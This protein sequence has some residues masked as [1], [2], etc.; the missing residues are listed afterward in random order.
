[1]LHTY[2][3]KHIY[4]LIRMLMILMATKCLNWFVRNVHVLPFTIQNC[5]ISFQLFANCLL[6]VSRNTKMKYSLCLWLKTL[7][8]SGPSTY[9]HLPQKKL[10]IFLPIKNPPLNLIRQKNHVGGSDKQ[11]T[12]SIWYIL[13]LMLL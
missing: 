6:N 4:I 10:M 1:M 5:L 2:F 13:Q 12:K 7:P 11:R 8:A 3:F 9:L